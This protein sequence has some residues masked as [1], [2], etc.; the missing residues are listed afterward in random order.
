MILDAYMTK[1]RAW[2]RDQSSPRALIGAAALVI[3]LAVIL[4]GDFA[5][6]V[7]E[8]RGEVEDLKREQRLE[9]SLLADQS[10][11]ERARDLGESAAEA[12]SRFWRGETAG[13]V[14]ARL[15]SAV[16]QAARTAELERIRVQVGPRAEPLAGDAVVF[17]VALEARDRRGQFLS[18]FQLLAQSEAQLTITRFEWA[19][20]TGALTMRVE[21][22]AIIAA[23]EEPAS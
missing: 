3:L 2:V 13:I 12:E 1:A 22:P 10:W 9:R 14:S 20:R 15:Q 4:L 6:A 8:M 5:A 7:G 11:P 23:A 18:L 21:A 16:E 17:E 19:R